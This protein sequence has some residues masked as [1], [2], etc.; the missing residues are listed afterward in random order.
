MGGRLT[1]VTRGMFIIQTDSAFKNPNLELLEMFEDKLTAGELTTFGRQK[2]A[3]PSDEAMV[4]HAE[5]EFLGDAED[6][7]FP[8]DGGNPDAI[9]KRAILHSG[10]IQALRVALFKNPDELNKSKRQRR[11]TA[12]PIVSYWIAGGPRFEVYVSL[13]STGNEVHMLMMTP[14]PKKHRQVPEIGHPENVWAIGK[15][16]L[17]DELHDRLRAA[18]W[19]VSDAFELK[20]AWCQQTYS[21]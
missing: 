2:L 18:K 13:S 19:E 17:I 3:L 5:D 11:P 15:R 4:H 6:G 12:L 21:Y 7:Y 8:K 14:D 9:G 1:T 20:D 16:E 10:C